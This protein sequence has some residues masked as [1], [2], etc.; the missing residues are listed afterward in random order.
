MGCIEI[1][2]DEL[3]LERGDEGEGVIYVDGLHG[4]P[5]VVVTFHVLAV[6]KRL[7][8]PV[9]VASGRQTE[10]FLQVVWRS[11]SLLPQR[12]DGLPLLGCQDITNA[13]PMVLES[14]TESAWQA[15][16]C[17]KVA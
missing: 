16:R 5:Y 1:F 9:A 7:E 8:E 15:A 13:A 3:G 12:L 2:V 11:A 6:A 14:I 10:A 17:C 4:S